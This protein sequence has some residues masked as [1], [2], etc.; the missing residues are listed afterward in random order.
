MG[1]IEENMAP[2]R[3]QRI[4]EGRAK[5]LCKG[6]SS[7]IAIIGEPGQES[8]TARESALDLQTGGSPEERRPVPVHDRTD[9]VLVEGTL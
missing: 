6:G 7:L 1:E 3:N 4:Q 2:A 5:K 9:V 8:L